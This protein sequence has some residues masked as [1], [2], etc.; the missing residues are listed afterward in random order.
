ML[1]ALQIGNTIIPNQIRQEILVF[2]G[3]LAY[4]I[5]L[6]K[7]VISEHRNVLS[8]EFFFDDYYSGVTRERF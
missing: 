1:R 5:C 7:A 4:V 3:G 2:S 6:R 8:Y